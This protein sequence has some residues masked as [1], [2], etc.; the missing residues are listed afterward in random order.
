MVIKIKPADTAPKLAP[1]AERGRG[2]PP[3]GKEL[4]T[5]RIDADVLAHY[6]SQ[7]KGWQARL[8]DDI[9]THLKR[10]GIL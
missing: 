6:R 3:S 1:Q 7:G 10:R 2:R 8:N 4:V 9:K 5:M